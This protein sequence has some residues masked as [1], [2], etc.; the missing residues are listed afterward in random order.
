LDTT[1]TVTVPE[2]L[3]LAP[4]V[5]AA[6]LEP[7][8]LEHAAAAVT[9]AVTHPATASLRLENLDELIYRTSTAMRTFRREARRRPTGSY[10]QVYAHMSVMMLK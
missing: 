3:L 5:E 2:L 10:T 1:A 9:R 6:V 4:P 8:P 7:P